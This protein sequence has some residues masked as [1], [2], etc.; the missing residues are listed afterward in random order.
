MV[1]YVHSILM[2]RT[3]RLKGFYDKARLCEGGTI[4]VKKGSVIREG[5]E[6]LYTYGQEYCRRWGGDGVSKTAQEQ[7]CGGKRR[8]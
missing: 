4:R 5:E 8:A 3:A 1:I 7:R 2:R 6:I